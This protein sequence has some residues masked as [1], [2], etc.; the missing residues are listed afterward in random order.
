MAHQQ[1]G[2]LAC[3]AW[4]PV[5]LFPEQGAGRA[6]R[7]GLRHWPPPACVHGDLLQGPQPEPTHRNPERKE[8]RA[9]GKMP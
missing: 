7:S 3:V 9:S 6:R 2:V 8:R 1:P 4:Q 5:A